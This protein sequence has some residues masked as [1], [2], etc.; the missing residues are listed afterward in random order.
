VATAIAAPEVPP[1]LA[2]LLSTQ[3]ITRPVVAWCSG[4]F[5]AGRTAYAVALAS[6]QGGGTYHV[7]ERGE[8]MI[9][10]A[11][12]ARAA[13]LDCY[14]REQSDKLDTSLRQS[15]TIHGQLKPLWNTAV[16]CGFIEDTA[17]VCWQYSSADRAFVVVGRWTT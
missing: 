12:F 6:P 13:S 16:V 11:P 15:A 14:T 17:A 7:V 10:L 5:R 1:A 2:A 3:G 9:E 8:P 4:E